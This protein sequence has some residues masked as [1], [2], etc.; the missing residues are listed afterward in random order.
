M[1]ELTFEDIT[2]HNF[3]EE[4]IPVDYKWFQ[5]VANGEW[6]HNN[7]SF[8]YFFKYTT[9]IVAVSVWNYTKNVDR[10][11]VPLAFKFLIITSIL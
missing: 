5:L 9:A 6:L 10:I 3:W 4:L 7:V 8:R 2:V 11:S 1:M